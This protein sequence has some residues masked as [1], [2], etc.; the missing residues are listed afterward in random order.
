MTA[1]EVCS[2][3]ISSWQPMHILAHGTAYRMQL[4]LDSKDRRLPMCENCDSTSDPLVK[5]RL[6]QLRRNNVTSHNYPDEQKE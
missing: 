2:A 3:S 5:D 4:D 6:R 1:G